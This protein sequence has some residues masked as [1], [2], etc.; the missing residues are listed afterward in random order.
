MTIACIEDE[1]RDNDSNLILHIKQYETDETRV[2]NVNELLNYSWRTH[3]KAQL[4]QIYIPTYKLHSDSFCVNKIETKELKFKLKSISSNQELNLIV[5]VEETEA[6]KYRVK[7]ESKL[8]FCNFLNYDL[9][10]ASLVC[11]FN[12]NCSQE[13]ILNDNYKIEAL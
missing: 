12:E 9:S 1:L 3:K 10:V 5:F 11:K 7:I 6:F 8:L 2:L 4:L 13:T